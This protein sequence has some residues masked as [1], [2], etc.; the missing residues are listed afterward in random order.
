VFGYV[1]AASSPNEVPLSGLW[2]PVP[3]GGVRAGSH[4]N[5]E[6]GECSRE[7]CRPLTCK[8]GKQ[9]CRSTRQ[10]SRRWRWRSRSAASFID[11][12]PAPSTIWSFLT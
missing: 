10:F 5:R 12:A 1:Y 3:K 7:F 11:E 2:L 9:A 8:A 4:V 6:R